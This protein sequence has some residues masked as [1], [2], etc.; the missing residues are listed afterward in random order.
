MFLHVSVIL[1]TEG[2][3]RPIPKGRLGVWPGGG[4][5]AWGFVYEHALRQTPPSSQQMATDADGTHPTG[6]HSCCLLFLSEF[7]KT[8]IMLTISSFVTRI[9]I[10]YKYNVFEALIS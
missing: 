7:F 8:F 3:S 10:N 1:Y 6:M 9:L 4:L 2:V 5:Q